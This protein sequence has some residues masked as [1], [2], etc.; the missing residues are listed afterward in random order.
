MEHYPI[1]KSL[2]ESLEAVLVTKGSQ[3]AKDL[4]K[5]LNVP[6]QP[7]LAELKKRD[8]NKFVIVPD[9]EDTQYQC[10]GFKEYGAI[11]MR[12]RNPVFGALPHFCKEHRHIQLNVRNLP[13]VK[14]IMLKKEVY[15]LQDT[16]LLNSEGKRC[17]LK[18]GSKV[19]LFSI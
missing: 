12:C 9:I 4:A 11:L 16:I 18:K 14:R 3:L 13:V 15:F 6:A 7:L 1:P 10:E 5:E 2:W 8:S 19:I 17:G